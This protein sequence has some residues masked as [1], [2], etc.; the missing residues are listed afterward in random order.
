VQFHRA[1]A[2]EI[3][4]DPTLDPSHPVV[5]LSPAAL[6]LAS[7]AGPALDLV[8]PLPGR[9]RLAIVGSRAAHRRV[10]RMIGPIVQAAG[11]R[12]WSL[13]SG[14][15]LGVDGAAHRAA[16][17]HGLHQLAVLPCG[18]DR[19]YPPGHAKLFAS[20]VESGRAGV[21]FA[22]PPGTQTVRAM[23][24]S[25]NAVV[26]ALA[27][28][29][30]VA[31][32]GLRSGSRGTGTLAL[33]RGL[34][35]G[36]IAGSPGC[37]ALIGAGARAFAPPPDEGEPAEAAERLAASLGAWLDELG[38]ATPAPE[39]AAPAWP[40]HL[41]WLARELAAAGPAGAS[42]DTLSDP[43]RASVALCEAE[44]LGL[45]CEAAAGRWV[46]LAALGP[47]ST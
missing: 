37:G 2:D 18:R 45:V 16:L 23:F 7:A 34:P 44:L 32:A 27:D 39:L 4:V 29:L 13:V 33:R 40:A 19:L 15:A 3:G 21:V 22:Q 25:R 11:V 5:P 46:S 31:E 1:R 41:T 36:A 9:P 10:L 14:G 47:A 28:A 42:I 38:G 17:E 30:L 43:A 20:M 6:G 35:V 24:A 26:V 12:G 8:G